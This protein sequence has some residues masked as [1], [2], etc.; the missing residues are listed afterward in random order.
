MLYMTHD[1]SKTP[2]YFI[3]FR[4]FQLKTGQPVITTPERNKYLNLVKLKPWKR[5][6]YISFFA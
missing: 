2:L 3:S 6:F 5:K 4:Y 1:F